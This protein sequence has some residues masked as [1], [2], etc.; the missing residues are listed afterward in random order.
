MCVRCVF[1][2]R[3][4]GGG[5]AASRKG[6]FCELVWVGTTAKRAFTAFKFQEVRD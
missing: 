5:G 2:L 4:S 6:N 3:Y 1:V